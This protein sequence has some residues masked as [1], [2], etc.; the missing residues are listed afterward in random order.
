MSASKH[1]GL[2]EMRYLKGFDT[3]EGL[4]MKRVGCEGYALGD[5]GCYYSKLKERI[6]ELDYVRPNQKLGSIADLMEFSGYKKGLITHNH[7]GT[8]KK[9]LSEDLRTEQSKPRSTVGRLKYITDTDIIEQR[10][11]DPEH[12]F[13]FTFVSES[14]SHAISGLLPYLRRRSAIAVVIGS[15]HARPHPQSKWVFNGRISW[16]LQAV[17]DAGFAKYSFRS[18]SSARRYPQGY[19]IIAQTIKQNKKPVSH[20]SQQSAIISPFALCI[21]HRTRTSPQLSVESRPTTSL[22]L[23]ATGPTNGKLVALASILTNRKSPTI[24]SAE[25]VWDIEE[26]AHATSRK[27]AAR[28]MIRLLV[29]PGQRRLSG[30]KRCEVTSGIMRWIVKAKVL[31]LFDRK[32]SVSELLTNEEISSTIY[33]FNSLY[34][35][36][37]CRSFTSY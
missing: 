5:R 37:I 34:P 10:R 33:S 4:V 29:K 18:P 31:P 6:T 11:C 21:I 26:P 15:G 20:F 3:S 7:F 17:M 27:T 12:Q 36:R 14:S 28:A 2:A 13:L 1:H 30:S 16:T 35:F 32:L 8:R 9:Q 23:A 19:N 25:E 22:I 24:D